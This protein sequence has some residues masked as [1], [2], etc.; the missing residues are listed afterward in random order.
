LYLVERTP[1]IV[2]SREGWALAVISLAG[3]T[4]GVHLLGRWWSRVPE[5]TVREWPFR[6]SA[7]IVGGMVIVFVA[8]ICLIGITHQIGWIAAARPADVMNYR[9]EAA[10][11]AQSRNQ[12]KQ[13]G[14]AVHNFADGRGG[15]PPGWTEDPAGRAL[16]GWPAHLLAY[17]DRN[18]LHGKL[19]WDLP[20]MDASNAVVYRERLSIFQNPGV[21]DDSRRTGG[22]YYPRMHYAGNMYLWGSTRR[23]RLGEITDGTAMTLLFGEA[24]GAFNPWG[25]TAHWRDADLGINRSPSGFG[26]PYLGGASF[27]LADGSV[28]FISD[29][30]DQSVLRT[31]AT[32]DGGDR[33]NDEW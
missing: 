15:L 13:F 25:A 4:A 17:L 22:D 7:T 11:R 32:P 10:R 33:L 6:W 31:L 30:I 20:W 12:L 29:K 14:L 2:W 21:D 3:A 18:D 28:R 9:S 24:A 1:R 8:A 5:S 26:S 23:W 27:C 16:H 19:R